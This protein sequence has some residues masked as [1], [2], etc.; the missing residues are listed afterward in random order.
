MAN[1]TNDVEPIIH[2]TKHYGFELTGKSMI[3][4][5]CT[6]NDDP[7]RNNYKHVVTLV[8]SRFFLA[9]KFNIEDNLVVSLRDIQFSFNIDLVKKSS[10]GDLDVATDRLLI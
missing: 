5:Q 3:D 8:S 7:Y 2:I 9:G 6:P 10:I 1:D 4:L